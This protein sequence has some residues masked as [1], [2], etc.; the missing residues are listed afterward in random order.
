MSRV[1]SILFD[2]KYYT[3]QQAIDWAISHGFKVKKI[4]TT[5]NK[6]RIRQ[7]NPSKKFSYAI[8]YINDGLEFVI[9][10]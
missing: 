4:D 5:I 2:R 7:F 1:Q 10:Y 3:K 6:F 8:H 9:A